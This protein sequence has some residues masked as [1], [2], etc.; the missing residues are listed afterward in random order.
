[1][2][3]FGSKADIPYAATNAQPDQRRL[4]S[5]DNPTLLADEALALAAPTLQHRNQKDRGC[6]PAALRSRPRGRREHA[7]D[8]PHATRACQLVGDELDPFAAPQ[9]GHK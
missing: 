3:A 9:Q 1:V 8:E 7:A 6:D 2:S 4:H 5:I